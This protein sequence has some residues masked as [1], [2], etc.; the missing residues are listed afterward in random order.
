MFI[1]NFR[2]I[3]LLEL[4]I[5]GWDNFIPPQAWGALKS[6]GRI[7]L[8]IILHFCMP[9]MNFFLNLYLIDQLTYWGHRQLKNSYVPSAKSLTE[10]SKSSGRS[11][12]YI[13]RSNGPK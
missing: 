13:R 4:K 5:H 8:K 6:P 12:M 3:E 2:S 9:N 7:G 11:F 10:D 1:P